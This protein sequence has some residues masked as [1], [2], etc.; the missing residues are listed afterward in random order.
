MQKKIII[1]SI[2]FFILDLISK[3]IVNNFVSLTESIAVINNFFYLTNVHNLGA[4]WSLFSGQRILLIVIGIAALFF[5]FRWIND[6]KNNNKNIWAFSLLISGLLGNLFDRIIYG[7]VRDFLDFRFGSY[8]YP[9]FNLAD[10]FIF[11]GV[12][13]LILAIIKGEENGSKSNRK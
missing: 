5:I 11:C 8:N 10:T 7:Y 2:I 13:V 12:I 3:V 4:A 6:F 9:V 1:Y